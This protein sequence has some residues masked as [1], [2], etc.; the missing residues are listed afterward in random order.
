MHVP[1]LLS[2]VLGALSVRPGGVYVDATVGGGGHSLAIAR[3]LGP[4]GTLIGIDRDPSALR[5]AEERL[6]SVDARVILI[7]ANFRELTRALAPTGIKEVDGVLFDLGFSSWQV[8]ENER[9]LSYRREAKLDMRLDP[10]EGVSAADLVNTLPEEELARIIWCYGEERWA[11]AI[12]R[13]IVRRRRIRP[14]TTT[15]EL[16]HVV[17]QAIPAA[18]RRRGPHPARR[19]FQALRIAV[20]R[21]LEN[22]ERG[23]EEAVAILR[24]GGRLAVISFHSL[25]DRIVK[26]FFRDKSA[27][28]VCPP[29]LPVCTCS[30]RPE[31]AVITRRPIRPS[32][33]EVAANPRARS[34]RLRVAERLSSN[35]VGERIPW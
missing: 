4:E 11:K 12:A 17:K 18:S 14:I 31:L 20:N 2:E 9:G 3:L 28:C 33:A 1:V 25:E 30:R 6:K 15:V 13:A 19:T 23:L 35:Q 34:A 16:A 22:L 26:R 10:T 21:E 27:G 7:K 8:E 29:D 5:I 24:P 32:P